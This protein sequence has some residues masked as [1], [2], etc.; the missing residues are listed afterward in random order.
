MGHIIGSGEEDGSPVLWMSVAGGVKGMR[1]TGRFE[2]DVVGPRRC[3]GTWG[4]GGR[5]ACPQEAIVA[6]DAQCQACRGVERPECVFEPLCQGQA[7]ACLCAKDFGVEH[8]VYC[9]F[10]GTLP[11][12]GMTQARRVE[13]R[14]REQGADLYFVVARGLARGE[15]R[16]LERSIS[17]LFRIPEHR[18]QREILPQLARPVPWETVESRATTLRERMRPHHPVEPE[19]HRIEHPVR[20]PLPGRPL[21]VRLHG[22]HAGEWLGAKGRHLFYARA[23]SLHRLQTGSPAVAAL[24]RWDLL[25]QSVRLP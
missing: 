16:T 2:L 24:K 3:T 17:Y 5:L 11:K 4:A 13:T 21:P 10:Y 7:M 9:A 23:P 15:A 14:L 22:V 1:L 25:G 20:Q 6:E 19:L 12:V 18:S 8:L